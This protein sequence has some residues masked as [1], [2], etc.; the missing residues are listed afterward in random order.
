MCNIAGYVGKR[1]AA[2]IL[3]EMLKRQENFDGGMTAG[4]ATIHE[5][6]LYSV[7]CEGTVEDLIKNTDAMNLPGNIGIAHTRPFKDHPEYAHPF[8]TGGGRIAVVGNGTI[9]DVLDMSEQRNAAVNELFDLGYEFVTQ[10]DFY[11][12]EYPC[13]KN[14]KNV[15]YMEACAHYVAESV[16]R[17]AS[18]SE[19]MAK[20]LSVNY[21]D[22]VGVSITEDHPDRIF[23]TRVTRP[24]NVVTNGE[25]SF[26]ATSAFAFPP[27]WDFVPVSLPAMQSCEIYAGG[28]DVTPYRV[29]GEP[30]CEVTVDIYAKAYDKIKN[31]LVGKKDAP[32]CYDDVEIMLYKDFPDMWPKKHTLAQYARV[33]YEV[34]FALMR[35]GV[36]KMTVASQNSRDR[37]F[38]YI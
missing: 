33:A 36:L 2:P 13:L 20:S 29:D 11:S 16:K 17:G 25:E 1:N 26:I 6:R 15:A 19:A 35:E 28:Y 4:I 12:S 10:K 27:E 3:L 38:M 31:A 18:Y 24:M 32:L 7:K 34:L 37:Y 30:V 5:G 9:Q 14:G 21:A 23:A 22:V 8:I